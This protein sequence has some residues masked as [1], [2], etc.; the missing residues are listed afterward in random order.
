MIDSDV[1]VRLEKAPE[2]AE[3]LGEGRGVA[4]G[5]TVDWFTDDPIRMISHSG[6]R[7]NLK[8]G[9]S[10]IGNY[11]HSQ[12]LAAVVPGG[13]KRLGNYQNRFLRFFNHLYFPASELK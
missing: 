10:S 2:N 1:P 6:S 11:P 5:V 8:P 12:I 9:L 4:S 7:K 13:D 3:I